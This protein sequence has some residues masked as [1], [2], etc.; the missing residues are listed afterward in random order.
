MGSL[1]CY[2]LKEKIIYIFTFN[3]NENKKKNRS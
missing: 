3:Q 1:I 2:N